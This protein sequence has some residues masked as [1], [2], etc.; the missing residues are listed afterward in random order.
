MIAQSR[1]NLTGAE[2]CLEEFK[3]DN[4]EEQD[5]SKTALSSH[6]LKRTDLSIRR[7]TS[8]DAILSTADKHV[9][10]QRTLIADSRCHERLSH[11]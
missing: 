11:P 6:T 7:V 4:L 3:A 1:V 2:E 9:T 8:N 10:D 5:Q